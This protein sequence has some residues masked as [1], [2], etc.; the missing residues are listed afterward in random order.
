MYL[1][2]SD[3]KVA[4]TCPAKLFYKKNRYPSLF[5]ENPYLKFLA[6]GGYMVEK[7]AKLLFEDGIEMESWGEPE[8]AFGEAVK[9][10]ETRDNVVM[11][12]PT[13]IHGRY[14]ARIDVLAKEGNV[15]KLI[16]VKS[17]SID[18]A[19]DR[20]NPFRGSKGGI[21]SKWRPYL[22]D[23]AFQFLVLSEAFPDHDVK[24][25]LC[26]VDKAKRATEHT[27]YDQFRLLRNDNPD[28]RV[29]APEVE[30]LGDVEYLRKNHLLA[31]LDVSSE[32]AEILDDVKEAAKIFAASLGMESI[33]RLPAELSH[34]CKGCEYRLPQNLGQK[35][36]FRDCWG[37]LADSDPH[38]L[39]LYRIDL[40][41]GKNHNLVAEL[42]AQGK[43]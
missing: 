7:M 11:F 40:A 36:G 1:T 20:A 15:L 23:V 35:N 9:I 42:A 5:D 29:W 13:V 28:V 10:I 37:S 24:P 30:F 43:S 31:I 41:G 26:V 6:D 16:E 18:S 32:V 12:E 14:S 38:M 8:K 25:Y 33:T 3:F 27:T 39:D 34:K 22:E 17:S 21:E 19:S 2:K 4:R